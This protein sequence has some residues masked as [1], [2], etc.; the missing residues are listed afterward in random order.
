[1]QGLAVFDNLFTYIPFVAILAMAH[2]ASSRSIKMMERSREI[3]DTRLDTLIAPTALVVGL[4]LIWFVNVPSVLASANLID[5][6]TPSNTTEARFSYFKAAVD[7]KGLAHQEIVEQLLT[8]ASQAATDQKV[9][10]D[11]RQQ[12]V[13]F[14]GSEMNKELERAPNDARLHLQYALFYRSIGA[15]KEAQQESAVA[16]SLSPKKQTIMLEQGIEAFQQ[17][18]FAAAKTYF[19]QAYEL[20]KDNTDPVNYMAAADIVNGNVAA[21]KALL[22][23]VFGTTSVNHSM[24]VLAYYQIGDWNDLIEVIKAK[25]AQT[26]DVNDEFQLAAAY[27]QA[28]RRAEAIATVH[29]AIAEHPEAASDGQALLQQ[30][31]SGK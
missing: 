10:Q 29:A 26:H 2:M 1:V 9:S 23:Q 6:L 25:V 20:D 11:L 30:L 21:G 27:S 17:K 12:I 24:L 19:T 16:R 18:D 22:Q 3:N 5:G 15:Y 14:A 7:N 28:G 4:L 31:G 8:F 13:D